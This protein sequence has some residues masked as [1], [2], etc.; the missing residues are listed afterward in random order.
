[1]TV[2]N[3]LSLALAVIGIVLGILFCVVMRN[4]RQLSKKL[5][6]FMEAREDK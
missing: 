5:D 4:N 3:W 1:M 2:D 6:E